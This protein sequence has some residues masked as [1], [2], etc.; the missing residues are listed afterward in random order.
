MP[1]LDDIKTHLDAD[2]TIGTTVFLS[3]MPDTPDNAIAVFESN[4]DTPDASEGTKYDIIQFQILVRGPE[5]NETSSYDMARA[6]AAQVFT[7][8]HNA[9]IAGYVYVQA[10][11]AGVI[12]I[13]EDAK[14]RAEVS[15]NFECLK[16]R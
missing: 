4:G 1:L 3:F 15:I 14:N 12:P 11:N 16:S 5:R 7:S 2:A 9:T 8:L 10:L 6:K 13:G